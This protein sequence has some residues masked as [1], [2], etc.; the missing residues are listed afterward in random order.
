MKAHCVDRFVE[1]DRASIKVDTHIA[2]D[3]KIKFNKPDIVVHDKLQ[4]E[5]IIIEIGITS[6][7]NLKTVE[8]EKTR[9]YELLAKEL[10]LIYK[11]STRIIPYVFTWDGL[12]TKCH[13]YYRKKLGVETHTE[14]Y[15]QSLIL[16]K[17]FESISG[18][19]KRV[20]NGGYSAYKQHLE[21]A[22]ER[23][24]RRISSMES[25]LKE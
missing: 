19:F 12:V 10:G 5:I 8:V 17:T 16:K 22:S 21:E 14:A 15:I 7:D 1:N 20:G 4:N 18:D 13:G 3:V 23:I 2:T 24:I 25:R 11:C 9:K 6:I